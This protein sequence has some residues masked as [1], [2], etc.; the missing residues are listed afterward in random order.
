M[1]I[2]ETDAVVLVA[3]MKRLNLTCTEAVKAM[4]MFA[5][6]KTFQDDLDRLYNNDLILDDSWDYWHPNDAP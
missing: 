1:N 6:D 2:D 3:T 5:N 4:Q